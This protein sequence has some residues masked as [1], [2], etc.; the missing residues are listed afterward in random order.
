MNL[1]RIFRR[2]RRYEVDLL[3]TAWHPSIGYFARPVRY[4]PAKAAERILEAESEV[5]G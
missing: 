4:D 1:R 2:R 5:E 3:E